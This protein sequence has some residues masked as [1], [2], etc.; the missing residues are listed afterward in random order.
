MGSLNESIFEEYRRYSPLPPISVLP[1]RHL[2][3]MFICK[4]EKSAVQTGVPRWD[5]YQMVSKLQP[6]LALFTTLHTIGSINQ[7]PTET[8]PIS[9][10]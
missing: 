4:G 8:G 7:P 5:G 9:L 2:A 3:S 6:P 1:S 10:S